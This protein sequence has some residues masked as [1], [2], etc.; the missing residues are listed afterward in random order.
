MLMGT[1]P[2]A[3]RS[4]SCSA[5]SFGILDQRSKRLRIAASMRELPV[6]TLSMSIHRPSSSSPAPGGVSARVESGAAPM[7]AVTP[8]SSPDACTLT[9]RSR[10]ALSAERAAK[11]IV[12]AVDVA[13]S[14]TRH[15]EKLLAPAEGAVVGDI[16]KRLAAADSQQAVQKVVGGR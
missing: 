3:V 1:A 15:E 13:A 12:P 14:G 5:A 10:C 2:S 9:S 16:R 8:P 4:M 6:F 7:A 11:G